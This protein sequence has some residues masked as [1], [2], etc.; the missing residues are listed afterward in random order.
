[1]KTKPTPAPGRATK[2]NRQADKPIK[3]LDDREL[4]QVG[5][6]YLTGTPTV[7]QQ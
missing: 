5:G 2:P 6:G 1:M 3:A 4:E 7:L